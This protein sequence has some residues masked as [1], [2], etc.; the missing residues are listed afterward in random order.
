MDWKNLQTHYRSLLNLFLFCT[1]LV[2]PLLIFM[3]PLSSW[4]SMLYS[5]GDTNTPI[6]FFFTLLNFPLFYTILTR[7]PNTLV[8]NRVYIFLFF[9]LSGLLF[10]VNPMYVFDTPYTLSL[11]SGST[12]VLFVILK[13]FTYGV[14]Q[15][16]FLIFS[17][18]VLGVCGENIWA[19]YPA[20][21]AYYM[22]AYTIGYLWNMFNGDIKETMSGLFAAITAIPAFL[23]SLVGM[24][25]K[26]SNAQVANPAPKIPFME[27]YGILILE[28]V[29]I[30]LFF[31]ARTW[32]QHA[33]GGK[34]VVHKPLPLNKL[35]SYKVPDDEQYE[36]TLTFW[37]YLDAMSPG[38]SPAASEFTNVVLYGG[39]V[40][41]AYNGA[42]NTL[43]I[44]MKNDE[45]KHT[46]DI[47]NVSLQKW[48]Q[49]GLMYSNGTFD[50]FMNGELQKSVVA[51]PQPSNHEV[52]VGFEKGVH[53]ELCTMMFYNQLL[54]MNQLRRLYTQFKDKTPPT[55]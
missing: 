5:Y 22:I 33:Y 32:V 7:Q 1:A 54:T 29:L 13:Y 43:R 17:I 16:I 51:I 35:V 42:L 18:I 36:Y 38:F 30:A 49:I 48:N 41:V 34:L 27:R 37:L 23:W 6:F 19:Y 9:L 15:H 52:L 45:K 39:N 46:Y 44:I 2:I 31:F 40:L 25:R 3:D 8:A 20:Y 24:A 10:Y 28:I 50:I 21:T 11:V 12:A 53:G 14:L 26:G 4:L 55:V 47:K